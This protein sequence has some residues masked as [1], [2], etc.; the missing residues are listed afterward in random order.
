MITIIFVVAKLAFIQVNGCNWISAVK[1]GYFDFMLF[2][3][4]ENV[5]VSISFLICN[6]LYLPF[7]LLNRNDV[8]CLSNMCKLSPVM[9]ALKS[10]K[11]IYEEYSHTKTAALYGRR[12]MIAA[13]CMW[14][15]IHCCDIG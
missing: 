3:I 10:V 7:L 1:I 15:R 5:I 9:V 8:L 14:R 4:K 13:Y 6:L 12:L 11:V 2:T